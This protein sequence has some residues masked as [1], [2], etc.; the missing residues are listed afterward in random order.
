MRDDALFPLRELFL[1][2]GVAEREHRHEV[3]VLRRAA[4]P[5][6]RRR[7]ASASRRCAAPDVASSSVDELAIELVVLGVGD[8]RPVEHVV[9]VR[10]VL[11]LLAQRPR[12]A[13][14]AR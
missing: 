6:R 4:L 1:V 3:R 13:P 9:L 12:R 11:E 14:R 2:E 10:R 7:A 8:R 5:A